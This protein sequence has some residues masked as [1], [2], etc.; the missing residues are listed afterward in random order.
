MSV[1][2]MKKQ[3][4]LPVVLAPSKED[5][6]GEKDIDPLLKNCQSNA[7]VEVKKERFSK[8]SKSLD[9]EQPVHPIPS[10]IIVLNETEK[11]QLEDILFQQ[12][13]ESVG[14]R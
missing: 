7:T 14:L 12:T 13:L 10:S 5:S 3:V 9:Y 6:N 1:K 8:T 4:S 2:M 11:L